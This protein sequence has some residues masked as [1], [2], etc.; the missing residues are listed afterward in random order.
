MR[1]TVGQ[2]S[3]IPAI[4]RGLWIMSLIL[5]A[6]FLAGPFLPGGKIPVAAGAAFVM[7]TATALLVSLLVVPLP[8]APWTARAAQHTLVALLLALGITILPAIAPVWLPLA[9]LVIFTAGSESLLW[10]V[11]LG[12][13]SGLLLAG[14][15]RPPQPLDFVAGML[16]LG[17]AGLAASLSYARLKTRTVELCRVITKMR[18]GADFVETEMDPDKTFRGTVRRKE[19]TLKQV[20]EEARTL[21]D[22]ERSAHLTQTL[23]PFLELARAMNGAHAA[24]FFDIDYARGGAF[25]RAQDG[26]DYIFTEAVLPLNADPVSFVLERKQP[27]YATDYRTLLWSLPYYKKQMHI[28]TLLAAPV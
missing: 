1:S 3:R 25:L 21:R 15:T 18:Q 11:T 10:T 5:S 8:K 9:I 22:L 27:F 2:R 13:G 7:L 4:G 28:G 19:P 20:S 6:L 24:L 14:A 17:G 23:A 12:L 16:G 26:P